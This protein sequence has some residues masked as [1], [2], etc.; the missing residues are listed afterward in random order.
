VQILITA[1]LI[2]LNEV[3]IPV[4][5]AVLPLTL[6]DAKYYSSPELS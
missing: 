1:E 6:I 5:S 2:P 4:F 3:S